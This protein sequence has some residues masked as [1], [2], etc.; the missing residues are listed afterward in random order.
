M[1]DQVFSEEEK[2]EQY[3]A[4]ISSGLSKSQ[5][6]RERG[7]KI[8]EFYYWHKCFKKEKIKNSA[9]AAVSTKPGLSNATEE[10]VGIEI[11]LPS[12]ARLTF[13]LARDQLVSF[14]QELCHAT[15]II[16]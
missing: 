8:N 10:I 5:F 4:W 7:L 2:R 14:V 1:L 13:S 6:C 11:Q 3:A 15:A 16:R 12:Q 9:F